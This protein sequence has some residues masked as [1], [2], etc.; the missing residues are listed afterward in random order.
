MRL[1]ALVSCFVT[2][3][4]APA[5]AS[6]AYA[7]S[8]NGAV[9]LADD[10]NGNQKAV[11]F[12]PVNYFAIRISSEEMWGDRFPTPLACSSIPDTEQIL[13]TAAGITVNYNGAERKY[14]LTLI[15]PGKVT[16]ET[17]TCS[18]LTN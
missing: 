13:C 3:S 2:L 1:F 17:G 10:G 6:S 18:W 9:G 4:G 14:A 15:E 12:K 8:G 7:C 11:R 5:Q 16:L